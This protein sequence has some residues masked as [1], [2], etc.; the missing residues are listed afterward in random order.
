MQRLAALLQGEL[1]FTLQE[2]VLYTVNLLNI[3]SKIQY[4]DE[5]KVICVQKQ[6]KSR[7]GKNNL[8]FCFSRGICIE[9]FSF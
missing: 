4:F 1:Q 7:V 2:E 5:E 9:M 8:K 3:G 6:K